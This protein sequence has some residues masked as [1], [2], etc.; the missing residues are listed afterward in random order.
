MN[1][2]QYLVLKQYPTCMAITSNVGLFG[3]DS[4][5]VEMYSFNWKYYVSGTGGR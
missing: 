5:Q 2:L 3:F 4:G 1:K